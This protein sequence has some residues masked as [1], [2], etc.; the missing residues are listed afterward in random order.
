[1]LEEVD[2]ESSEEEEPETEEQKGLYDT[3]VEAQVA[4]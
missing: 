4:G 3:E 2:E 1:M